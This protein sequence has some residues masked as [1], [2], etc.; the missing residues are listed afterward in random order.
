MSKTNQLTVLAMLA[1]M[2]VLSQAAVQ[3]FSGAT[4]VGA[5][6]VV[7]NGELYNVT[8]FDGTLESGFGSFDPADFDFHSETDAQAAAQALVDQV[9]TN[10]VGGDVDDEPQ[11]TLGITNETQSF[12]HIPYSVVDLG[13]A[14]FPGSINARARN[15]EQ[16][17]LDSTITQI[18]YEASFDSS[19]PFVLSPG[20][21]PGETINWA[22]F[23]LVPEPSSLA[24]LGLGGLLIARRRRG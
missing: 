14:I 10:T 2:P 19:I 16:E 13:N 8:F 5:T 9:F 11:L 18:L 20:G 4:L 24:L 7:V 15:H 12:T 3:Q 17:F 1:L 22:R 21:N 6:G 23:T